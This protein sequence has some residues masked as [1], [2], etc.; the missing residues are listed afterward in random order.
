MMR[1]RDEGR[2]CYWRVR[3]AK[4]MTVARRKPSEA[5]RKKTCHNRI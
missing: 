2:V 4:R 1:R 3:W 5:R